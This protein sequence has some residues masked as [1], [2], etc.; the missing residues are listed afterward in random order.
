MDS[1]EDTTCTHCLERGEECT[2]GGGSTKACAQCRQVKGKCSLVKKGPAVPSMPTKARKRP[3]VGEAEASKV[4]EMREKGAEVTDEAG[5][6][7]AK[8]CE[9]IATLSGSLDGLTTMVE[10]Q[11]LILGRLAGMM[12]EE[13]DWRRWRRKR[14]GEPVIPPAVIMGMGDEEEEEGEEEA[15][16][17]GENEEDGE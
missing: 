6:W 8:V 1:E 15:G 2:P 7:G 13:S 17:E 4:S 12:E 16:N 11:T 9:G 5:S 3:R 10:R 14:Q